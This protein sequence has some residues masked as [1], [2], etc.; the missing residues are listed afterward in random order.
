MPATLSQGGRRVKSFMQIKELVD[1]LA[2]RFAAA[3]LEYAHG[4]DNPWDEALYLV[5]ASLGLDYDGPESQLDQELRSDQLELL[6]QRARRR[7]DEHVPV[8]YLV[9]EAWFAGYRFASDARALIPRSPIAEL[10]QQRFEPLL[11]APPQRILD[12]CAGGGCIGIAC[13]L[14]FPSAQVDLTDIS[15]DALALANTNIQRYGL[16]TRVRTVCADLFAGVTG[17]Y[18]LIVSNPP[19]VGKTEIDSLAPEFRHEPLLG[20]HSDRNG[21]AIPLRILAAAA[22]YLTPDG[23]LIM[24]VGCS[25]EALQAYCPQ[26]PFLWLEFERGGEGVLHLRADQL[27]RYRGAFV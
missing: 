17:R 20:L 13:A 7:I 23:S 10:I 26:V 16:T 27:L 4:T 21:L 24:E 19:Y 22:D 5:F 6:E 25:A 1:Q 2:G 14:A 9:G 15:E 18:G 11:A 3:D 12:L 8:A